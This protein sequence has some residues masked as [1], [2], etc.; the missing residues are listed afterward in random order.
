MF[1]K[2]LTSLGIKHEISAF[3]TYYGSRGNLPNHDEVNKMMESVRFDS[4]ASG[5]VTFARY[6]PITNYILK[7]WDQ[8]L[9]E[10]MRRATALIPSAYGNLMANNVDGESIELAGRRLLGQKEAKKVMIVM[11][12]G[13]PASDGHGGNLVNHLKETVKMLSASG[14]EMLGLGLQD[15]SVEKF[16]PK[17]SVVLKADEIPQKILELTRTMVVGV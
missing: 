9:N 13:S 7:P 15:R 3:T 17:S 10:D 14:I 8:R 11:S 16:Y 6:A 4:R 1:S 12:D 5:G 2:V